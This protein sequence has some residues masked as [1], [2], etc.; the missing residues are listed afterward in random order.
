MNWSERVSTATSHPHN[1][2]IV[3]STKDVMFSPLSV[4]LL[5]I[6][7]ITQKLPAGLPRNLV[8]RCGMY[9]GRTH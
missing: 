7:K 5:V 6:N 8:N 3:P 2:H 4:S 1:S 9:Q